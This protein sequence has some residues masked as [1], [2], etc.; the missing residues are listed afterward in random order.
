MINQILEIDKKVFIYLNS[1]H[2]DFLDPIMLFL[3]YN[4]IFMLV[5]LTILLIL[6]YR[7]YKKKII[8]LFFLL[9]LVFGLSDSISTRV[10]K[11]NFK[12]LR[13]CHSQELKEISYLAGE[14]CWGGKF[15]FVSSHASNSFAVATFFWLL[16]KMKY[17]WIVLLFAHSSLVSFSRIY[18]AKHYPLDIICGGLL[19]FLIAYI[20]LKLVARFRRGQELL[21]IDLQ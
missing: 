11:D 14:K 7:V 1:L 4:K 21:K 15:G 20:T 8:P 19:G 2:S 17:T 3:S 9:L 18:L 5:L 13:P 12:R 16:L 6:T 10:F